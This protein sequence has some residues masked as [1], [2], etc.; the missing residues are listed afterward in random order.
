MI[1]KFNTDVSPLLPISHIM[2]NVQIEIVINLLGEFVSA[3]ILSK[4][5]TGVNVEF[6]EPTIVPVT[7]ESGCRSGTD[8]APHPLSDKLSYLII[9]DEKKHLEF[10]NLLAGWCN[11][12]YSDEK[13]MAVKRYLDH[14]TILVDLEKEKIL[15]S[16]KNGIINDK[17]INGKFPL[18]CFVRWRVLGAENGEE[19]CW[20][21]NNLF[22]KWID[23]YNSILATRYKDGI[24]MI[25]GK[26]VCLTVKTPKKILNSYPNAKIVSS[27]DKYNFV[28]RGR[29]HNPEQASSVG[30]DAFQ[31]VFSILQWLANNDS[32]SFSLESRKILC[33]NPKG[34]NIINIINSPF[35]NRSKKIFTPSDYRKELKLAFEGLKN[36]L[37]NTED[38]VI[39]ALDVTTDNTGRLSIV[40]Y[41]ELKG[42]DFVYRI[43]NW[44]GS[45][46]WYFYENIQSPKLYKIVKFAFGNQQGNKDD[47]KIEVDAKVLKLH[48]QRLFTCMIEMAPIPYDIVLALTTKASMPLCYNKNNREIILSTAN[49]IIRKYYND[50]ADKEEWT[51]SLDKHN[52][53]R[54]YLFGR[55]LAVMEQ[56]ERATYSYEEKREPNA[57][58][59]QSAFC[60]RPYN[61]M[62]ILYDRLLP[63]FAQLYPGSRKKYKNLIGEI[64]EKLDVVDDTKKNR[65]LEP[66][67]LMGYF[68][69]RNELLKSNKKQ[70]ED[71]ENGNVEQED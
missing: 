12:K 5:G 61:T 65:P 9:T 11:S 52:T 14:G 42:S 51:M 40:Y 33:W 30:Y 41:N 48:M 62:A 63:Y 58:R 56:V 59:L 43:N 53:N 49:A 22:N 31:R 10:M 60:A 15:E 55:L 38:V 57:I 35:G 18:D 6:E 23:Y 26:S 67:Y 68:L 71:I 29:F 45:C 44:Y 69:Q 37:P 20:K 27:N 24:C 2:Q 70:G 50:K 28:F 3:K 13:I 54:S 32:T 36:E 19:A 39:V 16:D 4:V 64:M 21:D 8:P 46:Y 7:M 17:R 47:S 1:G 34:K 66:Q 25:T